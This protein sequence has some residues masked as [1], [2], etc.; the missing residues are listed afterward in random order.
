MSDSGEPREQIF[1]FFNEIGIIEQLARNQF[2]RIMPEGM[3][4]AHFSVLNHFVRLGGE[5]SPASLANAFQVT[6]GAM[7]NTLQRLESKGFIEIRPD[8]EDGRGKLVQITES[9]RQA[10][11]RAIRALGPL[12]EFAVQ[13]LNADQFA[14]AVPFLEKVRIFLDENRNFPAGESG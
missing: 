1:R 13:S 11:I 2:E 8:P 7:T 10:H 5:Q 3:R 9:G 12:L 6:K 14:Q 4:L